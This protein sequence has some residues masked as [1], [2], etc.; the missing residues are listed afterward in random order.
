[1]VISS[2]HTQSKPSF[3]RWLR[4]ACYLPWLTY[5]YFNKAAQDQIEQAVIQA[6]HGTHG[7]IRV[8]IEGNVPAL[9]AYWHDTP[10]R[11]MHLFSQLRVWDTAHNS[12][13]LLYVNI[14]ARKVELLADRGIHAFVDQAHWQT[15]CDQVSTQ[16]QTGD[17]LPAVLGGIEQIGQTLQAFYTMQAGK[18]ENEIPN[19]PVLL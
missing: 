2:E 14:C 9:H 1:M 8:V 6:E 17:Y 4:H 15:I 5:R 3:S 13:V 11:A 7:E 10:Q 18:D 12:G 16:L 19:R